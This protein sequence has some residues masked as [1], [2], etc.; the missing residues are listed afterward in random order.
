MG[1]QKTGKIYDIQAFRKKPD[2]S[3]PSHV[4]AEIAKFSGIY[5][6][7]HPKHPVAKELVIL[8]GSK[9]PSC[10]ACNQPITFWLIKQ[11]DEIADDPDFA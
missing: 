6:L 3:L 2:E 1:D 9:F 5:R 4:S 11:A 8:K 7:E 10:P